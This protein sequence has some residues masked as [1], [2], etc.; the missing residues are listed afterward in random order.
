MEKKQLASSLNLMSCQP[1][2]KERRKKHRRQLITNGDDYIKPHVVLSPCVL[3]LHFVFLSLFLFFFSFL[4][5]LCVSY[6]VQFCLMK[7]FALKGILLAVSSFISEYIFVVLFHLATH[8]Q[9]LVLLFVM[10]TIQHRFLSLSPFSR[11]TFNKTSN[12]II[13]VFMLEKLSSGVLES[14]EVRKMMACVPQKGCRGFQTCFTSVTF[15]CLILGVGISEQPD[16]GRM[17]GG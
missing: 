17:V 8:Q 2:G 10:A 5:V 14:M 4:A 1:H 16:Q 7:T 3:F 12:N 13:P 11:C 9:L 6:S 15:S